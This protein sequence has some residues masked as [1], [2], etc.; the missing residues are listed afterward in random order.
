MLRQTGALA[1]LTLRYWARAGV[2]NRL[3]KDQGRRASGAFLRGAFLLLMIN[4]GYRIGL[5]C[6][7][8]EPELRANA[9]AFSLEDASKAAG[10][11]SRSFLYSEMRAGRLASKMIGK[12]RVIPVEAL[13]AWINAAPD[14]GTPQMPSVDGGR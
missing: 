14:G 5:A 12:R 11:I 13:R 3:R 10:G 1:L 7:R 4:W 6:V 9:V 8:V 2:P